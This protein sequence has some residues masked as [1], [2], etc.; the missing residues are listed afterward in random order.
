MRFTEAVTAAGLAG[1]LL[2]G[3]SPSGSPE[4]IGLPNDPEHE[5]VFDANPYANYSEADCNADPT[6]AAE[7]IVE[8]PAD[9]AEQLPPDYTIGLTEGREVDGTPIF[10]I[11]ATIR[12]LGGLVYELATSSNGAGESVTIN[13]EEEYGAAVLEAGLG[14][15]ALLVVELDDHEGK[16]AYFGLHCLVSTDSDGENGADSIDSLEPPILSDPEVTITA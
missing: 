15:F 13:L 11:G 7:Y 16:Q 10:A 4:A 5:L 6:A 8:Q 2:S 3:C 14:H 9:G 1:V 12:S